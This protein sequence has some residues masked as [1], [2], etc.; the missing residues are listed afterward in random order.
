MRIFARGAGNR[1][2]PRRQ[3][4]S[5]GG[6]SGESFRICLPEWR[7]ASSESG[8]RLWKLGT[9]GARTPDTSSSTK[10]RDSGS[11]L[12]AP[13]L[14]HWRALLVGFSFCFG[15]LIFGNLRP[16]G[17][18]KHYLK[19]T[20]IMADDMMAGVYGAVVLYLAGYFQPLLNMAKR[21]TSETTP[22]ILEVTPQ[23]AIP[24]G[25]FLIRGRSFTSDTRPVRTN[26]RDE[27]SDC[28]RIKI[29]CR[30]PC[31]GRRQRR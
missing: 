9:A 11:R 16:C 10:W 8:Q 4:S 23:A 31:S 6:S 28:R 19:G 30:R 24:G 17:N 15:F 18:S 29:I 20:G 21:Q 26:R 5:H 22:E 12:P 2:E 14:F 1:R 7:P 13:R 25:E 27:R 3:S